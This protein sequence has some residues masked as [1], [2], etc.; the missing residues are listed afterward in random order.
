MNLPMI[1]TI[2]SVTDLRYETAEIIKLVN[3][4]R[5]IVVTKDS[6]AVAVIFS[7][8]QYQQLLNFFEEIED[9][10]DAAALEKAI[11]K[12]EN[13]VEFSSFDKK[14]KKKLKK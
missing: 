10:K 12:R 13:F 7:P 4:G 5:S 11:D 14:M 1:P 6:D 9:G 8:K 2:K 3:E